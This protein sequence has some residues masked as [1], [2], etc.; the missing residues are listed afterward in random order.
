MMHL[1]Y[2]S[3]VILLTAGV[4]SFTG[5]ATKRAMRPTNGAT[6]DPGK[7]VPV[8]N[9]W[10]IESNPT[11]GSLPYSCSF[12]EFDERG[13]Y[14]DFRQ[15]KRSWEK[16]KELA[17]DKKQKLVFVIYCHGWK[18]NS[19]S[20]NVVEF[21]RFLERLAAS[22]DITSHHLRVHGL[23]LAWRGN[24]VRPFI[25][26]DSEAF[27]RTTKD[28]GTDCKQKTVAHLRILHTV[29][30]RGASQLLVAQR[31]CRIESLR[32]SNCPHYFHG[33]ECGKALQRAGLDEPRFRDRPLFWRIDARKIL[34]TGLCRFVDGSMEVG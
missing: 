1:S 29:L 15:Q 28:W 3:A 33:R 7:D 19:Q 32:C 30:D 31:G 17:V 34:G 11:N 18:N 26:R 20:G 9:R 22:P 8:S 6:G 2:V 16:I 25:D 23:Y 4:F 10:Y 5:C 24:V 27:H 14:L 21:N 12:V 13:D